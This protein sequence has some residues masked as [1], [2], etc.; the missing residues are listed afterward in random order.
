[1]FYNLQSLQRTRFTNSLED[2]IIANS[3]NQEAEIDIRM[4]EIIL[5]VDLEEEYQKLQVQESD[6]SYLN[7]LITQKPI[8]GDHKRR[9]AR[10][11]RNHRA[12]PTDGALS[13]SKDVWRSH[14]AHQTTIRRRARRC[15]CEVGSSTGGN[16]KQPS[17]ASVP[18]Q[19]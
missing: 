12:S 15:R 8:D 11:K 7:A 19:P 5:E 9:P 13:P 17:L 16:R 10:R 4:E 18:P 6:M 3:A 2:N 1:M 14:E